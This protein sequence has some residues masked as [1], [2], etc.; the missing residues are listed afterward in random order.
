MNEAFRYKL[1]QQ[2]RTRGWAVILLHM[3]CAP[4]ASAVYSGKQGNWLPFGIATA[5]FLVGVPLMV[6]DLG[7][8]AGIIAPIV[9]IVMLTG[10]ASDARRQLGVFCPEQADALL[11]NSKEV[12]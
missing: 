5:V 2:A 11:Y 12:N 1:I 9:S 8:T 6:V 7:V 3:L 4:I 10:K